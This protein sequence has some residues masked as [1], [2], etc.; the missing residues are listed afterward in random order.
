MITKE[1]FTQAIENIV[2]SYP[3][4]AA[5]YKANDP[6]IRQNLE[7]Q[8][9][10]LA[11]FS[12]QV[13]TSSAEPFEKVRDATVLADAAMRGIIRKAKPAVVTIKLTNNGTS[14]YTLAPRQLFDSSGNQYTITSSAI[15][16]PPNETATFQA[17]QSTI[18]ELTHTVSESG[19]PFYAIEIPESRDGSYLTAIP[20]VAD[21]GDA[22]T[23]SER[24]V[25]VFAGDRVFHVEADDRQR[26]YVR[27]GS[28]GVGVIP[29]KGQVITVLIHRCAGKIY[30]AAKSPF[31]FENISPFDLNIALNL[32]IVNDPGEN[33][34]DIATLREMI[35][36]PSVYDH[37]AVYLGE[38]DFLVRRKFPPIADSAAQPAGQFLSVWNES[39]EEPVRG[40]SRYNINTLF[41]ACCYDTEA[42][43]N[44]PDPNAQVPPGAQISPI[45]IA[46][47]DLTSRQVEIRDLILGADDSYR[48]KFLTPVK[49]EIIMSV[50]AT[51]ST[52][53]SAETTRKLIQDVLIAEFGINSPAATRGLNKPL[54]QRIYKIL[55]SKVPALKDANSDVRVTITGHPNPNRPEL[56]RHVAEGSLTIDVNQANITQTGWG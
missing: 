27:F 43:R 6:R 26:V 56:W 21:A 7:A 40:A 38:F 10:M 3:T 54:Y 46:E 15:T 44:E 14:N 55:R 16:V 52:A 25:N 1:Q 4:I 29:D 33:P 37:N 34:P 42:I 32:D 39:M 49:S 23:Y 48:V 51:I 35:K 11:M 13:E 47:T 17:E 50:T 36:Y 2:G 18:E 19:V 53:Y 30:P 12:S 20:A 28:A 45:A 24:Y 41:V 9:T 22:Y 5:L 31:S 8:A